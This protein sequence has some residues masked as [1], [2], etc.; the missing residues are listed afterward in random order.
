MRARLAD[1]L[2]HRALV[3]VLVGRELKA[4]YRGSVLGFL[5]SLV[6]PLLLLTVYAVVFQYVLPSR[7]ATSSPY[8]VFLFSGLLPWNWLA[9]ALNDAASSLVVSGG[10]LKKI[11]FPAEVLPLVS[12]LSQGLHFV[13]ALP[14]LFAALG[15]GAAGVFG[16]R[17]AVGWPLLQLPGLVLLQALLLAGL[18]LFLAGL[19]VHF[20]DVRDLLATA[21]TMWFFGTPVLYATADIPSDRLRALLEWNPA[22]PLFE[23]WHDALFRARWI[24]PSRWALLAGVA[25]AAFLAGWAFFDRLRD[26]YAEAV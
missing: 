4:R 8:V 25:V 3:S 1:L 26:S 16:P 13:L 15:L 11:L 6:N 22:T 17:V 14:V 12:V 18:G 20:R 24:A 2:R 21:I 7:S 9:S 23:A 10:L 19:T 5:W